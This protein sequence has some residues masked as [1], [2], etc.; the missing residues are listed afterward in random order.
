M[1]DSNVIV[2]RLEVGDIAPTSPVSDFVKGSDGVLKVVTP[3]GAQVVATAESVVA[4]ITAKLKKVQL[5]GTGAV[6]ITSTVHADSET[7]INTGVTSVTMAAAAWAPETPNIQLVELY[8][9]SGVSIPVTI[10]GF[11]DGTST[12]GDVTNDIGGTGTLLSIPVGA[13]AIVYVDAEGSVRGKLATQVTQ[14]ELDAVRDSVL[15]LATVATSGSYTDLVDVPVEVGQHLLFIDKRR[16][17]TYTANGS[18][19]K[20]FK[21]I[22][23]AIAQAV[24]NGD[25]ATT[26]YS[27]IIA[28]GT[29][30]EE[31][32]LNSV[33]LF[34]IS[35]IGL[36][37]VA[38]DPVSG[39]AFTC[40]TGNDTLKNLVIRNVEFA[41][42][43]VI[44]GN[45][46]ADQFSNVTFYDSAIGVLT[47]TCM[48][49]LNMRGAYISGDVTLSNVAWFYWDGVQHDAQTV[50]FTSDTT[51]TQPSWGMTSAGG[52]L[53]GGK[54]QDLAFVRT[55]A[56][57]FNLNLNSCY[58]GLTASSYTVPIG[59]T[60]NVRN[61]TLRGSWTNN[62]AVNLYASVTL[63][64]ILGTAP[65]YAGVR[66]P[67]SV[68]GGAD[69]IG[70]AGDLAGQTEYD[71]NGTLYV[72]TA[73]YDGVTAIWKVV[74][75]FNAK[76]R[77]VSTGL[78]ETA[79]VDTEMYS[80]EQHGGIY[81]TIYRQYF[82][83]T[84]PASLTSGSVV[85]KLVDYAINVLDGTTRHVVR[86]WST[87]GGVY[88]AHIELSGASGGGNLTLIL[89]T[90]TA[91]NG[92]VDYTK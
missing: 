92:W 11:S 24:T 90:F 20:P 7:H 55:G 42:P 40:T 65:S 83:A 80:P 33:G 48:N 49:S 9:D 13:S 26:P 44:T 58:V 62:G 10:S 87:N 70:V 35:I 54:F 39:N 88:T 82:G 85:T 27:F 50:S 69:G 34:D 23:A 71:A 59:F 57:A 67:S 52:Y 38:I 46:T 63:L 79:A 22:A 32:N 86:D 12:D 18:A 5:V 4:A 64:P 75:N 21:T 72:A 66:A 31:I 73:N 76:M 29:Y 91:Q 25:G 37:R 81:G 16:T 19:A 43:I 78:F 41:D 14:V 3:S 28:E 89:G 1:K 84:L 68:A 61:S 74:N 60:I 17:D 8:N 15:A 51:A 45:A 47:A 30:A 6:A 36:G 56:G 2:T 77:R 53:V